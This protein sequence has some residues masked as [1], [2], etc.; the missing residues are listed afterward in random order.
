VGRSE[1]KKT[2]SHPCDY[3]EWS[4]ERGKELMNKKTVSHLW[5]YEELYL[6]RGKD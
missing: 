3:K 4:L 1:C 5:A 2:V 6:K